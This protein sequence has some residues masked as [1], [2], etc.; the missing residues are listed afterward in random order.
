MAVVDS[1]SV[2]ERICACG[3]GRA[4]PPP[5]PWAKYEARFLVGHHRSKHAKRLVPCPR[6]GQSFKQYFGGTPKYC[7]GTCGRAAGGEK[8][9]AKKNRGAAN[10][11][12]CGKV[13]EA[14]K[15]PSRAG[16]SVFCS[17]ACMWKA[18]ESHELVP[19]VVCHTMF[20]VTP[21]WKQHG[22][23]YCSRECYYRVYK[24][25]KR[26]SKDGNH[27]TIALAFQSVGA[28][29]IHTHMFGGGFPDMLVC[30][31]KQIYSGGSQKSS[32]GLWPSRV[33]R[34]SAAP[35]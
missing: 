6:C 20:P 3:C 11:R 13:Y 34:T 9:A 33:E 26:A 14:R 27:N 1:I 25:R 30:F 19:C 8:N 5:L 2:E 10:C 16:R 28:N 35:S 29:V 21:F 12:Q 18:K 24:M 32:F 17:H 15:S 31:R 23:K 7:S 22:R 4:L